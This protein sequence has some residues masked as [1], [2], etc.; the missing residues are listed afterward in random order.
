MLKPD[1]DRQASSLG[2]RLRLF[3]ACTLRRKKKGDGKHL[4]G[5]SVSSSKNLMLIFIAVQRCVLL[6]LAA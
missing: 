2:L 6:R 1:R 5:A 4:G 3:S